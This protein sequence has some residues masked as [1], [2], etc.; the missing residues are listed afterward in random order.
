MLGQVTSESVTLLNECLESVDDQKPLHLMLRSPGGDPEAAIRLIRMCHGASSEF[1]VLV[2][3]QAKSAATIM[4]LGADK[5]V[6]GPTSDLGPIDP[7]VFVPERGF[8][9]AKDLI[10]AYDS[11]LEMVAVSPGTST[12]HAALLGGIDTTTVQFA[13]SAMER[14]G[15][16]ARQAIESNEHLSVED[17]EKLCKSIQGPLIDQPKVHGAVVGAREAEAAGLPIELLCMQDHQWKQI[18]KLWTRYFALGELHRLYAY[19]GVRAS[20]VGYYS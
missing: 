13:R 17:V 6:M 4:S 12:F 20:Q 1:R 8:V 19:E 7:Q 2:P 3:E 5:I 11:V 10:A 9:S 15:D 14:T 16:I 18:Q